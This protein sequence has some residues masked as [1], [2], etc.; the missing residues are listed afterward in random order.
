MSQRYVVWVGTVPKH[1]ACCR[2]RS[3]AESFCGSRRSSQ[4]CLSSCLGLVCVS[5]VAGAGGTR[6]RGLAPAR[7]LGQKGRNQRDGAGLRRWGCA[8]TASQPGSSWHYFTIKAN[9]S[10][11]MREIGKCLRGKPFTTRQELLRAWCA[12]FPWHPA[13]ALGA[14]TAPGLTA[15]TRGSSPFP[16][17]PCPISAQTH[18]FCSHT[19]RGSHGEDRAKCGKGFCSA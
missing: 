16:P 8:G 5:P 11:K 6:G 4:Q 15:E 19:L 10:F 14:R 3:P 13:W 17:F 12:G 2:F 1:A 9:F 7:E 18:P